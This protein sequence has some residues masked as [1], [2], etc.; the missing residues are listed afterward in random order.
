MRCLSRHTWL[1]LC[2]FFGCVSQTKAPPLDAAIDVITPKANTWAHALRLGTQTSTP[3]LDCIAQAA[4]QYYGAHKRILGDF[5]RLRANG[6]CG[7]SSRI[8]S[9][10]CISGDTQT[11]NLWLDRL[12][13]DRRTGAVGV[14]HLGDGEDRT[15][16]LV[17][18][19]GTAIELTKGADLAVN[20]TLTDTNT[21]LFG[22][23][24]TAS[25]ET[26]DIPGLRSH[27]KHVTVH[28]P[29]NAMTTEIHRLN[30]PLSRPLASFLMPD[31]GH[32]K[33][34]APMELSRFNSEVIA[35]LI[36][37]QRH[38]YQHPPLILNRAWQAP[39][40]SWIER[41]NELGP[42]QSIV[43]FLD[44]RG[45]LLPRTTFIQLQT[46]TRSSF[47]GLMRTSPTLRALIFDPH[48]T[49]IA[50][51]RYNDK[52]GYLMGFIQEPNKSSSA[53]FK[54]AFTL[55][56]NQYRKQ[57]NLKP[58]RLLKKPP[59]VREQTDCASAMNAL[60][61]RVSTPALKSIW[62]EV[63]LSTQQNTAVPSCM[64]N[65]GLTTSDK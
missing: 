40:T 24:L 56:L 9:V 31:K 14:G 16:C 62:I 10:Q 25:H 33:I 47:E 61:E 55:N 43:G 28:L 1:I 34:K 3:K 2:L 29:A 18:L 52:S 21:R 60:L 53:A 50:I 44:S 65:Y 7:A 20:V 49:S 36:N 19:T 45:W 51:R 13:A 58:L 12:P 64:M 39:L 35:E 26:V 23:V 63:Q 30:A 11:L 41:S 37:V 38:S 42:R 27:G 17:R 57:L 32:C 6:C 48:M 5:E 15:L 46:S 22:R 8:D 59:T 54:S 4:A